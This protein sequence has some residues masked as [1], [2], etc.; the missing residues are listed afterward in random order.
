MKAPNHLYE[1]T[2]LVLQG[3]GALGSYQAGA[4]E[5]LDQAG[6]YPDWFAGISIGAINAAIMAGN[7]PKDRV[8]RLRTFWEEITE[9]FFHPPFGDLLPRQSHAALSSLLGATYGIPGFF[10]PQIPPGWLQTPINQDLLSYYDTTPLR[11]TLLRYID[12]DRINA[13]DVRLSLGAVNVRTGN[14]AY[15]DNTQ[16]TIKPEH[17]MASGA[18]PPGFPPVRIDGEEYWDGGLVS[19]TPLAYVLDNSDGD[20]TL[21]FQIDLFSATGP[22]PHSMDMVEERRKDI[23]F[24]SRTRLNTD[25]FREKH[26]L[27]QAICELAKHLPKEKKSDPALAKFIELGESREVS[28]VHLIYRP[29][30]YNGPTKD[31]EFSRRSMREHWRAGL[32]DGQKTLAHDDWKT[33]P[34]DKQGI[35]VYDLT[36]KTTAKRTKK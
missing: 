34:S 14:F 22:M 25:E 28:I 16:L 26:A 6:V 13:K 12:F 24:S 31:Y 20:D 7:A 8:E 23:V 1:Q 3:G 19:N 29:N 15:F 36:H 9:T 35:A 18:L 21:I 17:I 11:N 32:H 30:H 33:P 10:V 5:S 2:A 4:Y 27:K